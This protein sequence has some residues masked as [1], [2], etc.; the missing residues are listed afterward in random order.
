MIMASSSTSTM[1]VMTFNIRYD[2]P[3]DGINEWKY[4][5]PQVIDMM[6]KYNPIIF[7]LQEC[8]HS[9]LVQIKSALNNEYDHIGCGRDDGKQLGEYSPIFYKRS[10]LEMVHNGQFWISKDSYTPG[11]KSWETVCPRVATW[12][13][14]K[15][16]KSGREFYFINTHLD[17]IS[18]EARTEGCMMIKSFI[19]YLDHNIPVVFVGDFNAY[20]ETKPVKTL[21]GSQKDIDGHQYLGYL[22][23][24]VAPG[25][26]LQQ[27]YNASEITQ[28]KTGPKK[29]FTGFNLEFE[30]TI[31]YIFV[32]KGFGVSSFQV[33]DESLKDYDFK[34]PLYSDHL[35]VIGDLLFK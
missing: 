16:T 32:N 17:H 26:S 22:K 29:T 10:E 18:E 33:V 13:R 25:Y 12:G 23:I 11:S 27:L 31:D 30:F 19:S 8:L 7:G 34:R 14:F 24:P 6:K 3:K 1:R 21:L 4:R 2:T 20:E 5:M 28:S 35:P 15:C 9:Q